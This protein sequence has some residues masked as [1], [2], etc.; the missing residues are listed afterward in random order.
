MVR[1]ATAGEAGRSRIGELDRVRRVTGTM[2]KIANCEASTEGGVS[3]HP[4]GLRRGQI[5][6]H[7]DDRAT[8]R[9]RERRKIRS[10][11]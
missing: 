7:F 4:R 9:C 11:T 3:K 6:R 2:V 8:G 10:P 1:A 5:L